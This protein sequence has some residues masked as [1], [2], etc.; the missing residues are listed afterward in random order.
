[1]GEHDVLSDH[2]VLIGSSIFAFWPEHK[3][4]SLPIRNN[5]IPGLI[6]PEL[7]SML[8]HVV[9]RSPVAVIYCGSNDIRLGHDPA[10]V[11]DRIRNI[12]DDIMR[13]NPEAHVVVVGAIRSPDQS[14]QRVTAFNDA[15]TAVCAEHASRCTFVDVNPVLEGRP[16]CFLDDDVH[17]TDV[18]YDN[19]G[20]VLLPILADVWRRITSQRL[21]RL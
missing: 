13:S 1:M 14:H 15:C 11:A 6:T 21:A 7:R 16:E 9:R 12:A 18:G 5:A 2:M 4:T 8:P 17:L 3:L 19:M 10:R 20:G